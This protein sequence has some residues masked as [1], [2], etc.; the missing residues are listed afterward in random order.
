MQVSQKKMLLEYKD[1]VSKFLGYDLHFLA[2]A[3]IM[4]F[5][6]PVRIFK[7]TTVMKDNAR[8]GVADI[9]KDDKV[10]LMKHLRDVA[11]S[12]QVT[13]KHIKSAFNNKEGKDEVLFTSLKTSLTKLYNYKG[14]IVEISQLPHTTKASIALIISGMKVKDDE[15]S[16]MMRAH[17]LMLKKQ[18]DEK[19]LFD[20]TDSTDEE[21][22]F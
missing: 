8:I 20:V 21:E 9:G 2:R 5:K 11:G 14:N 6:Q 15:A 18:E 4:V 16:Y 19:C 13:T 12:L 7:V 3:I 10:L 17:Q 1:N 22:T